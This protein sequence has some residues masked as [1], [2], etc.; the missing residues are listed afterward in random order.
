[1]LNLKL[2]LYHDSPITFSAELEFNFLQGHK[3][4]RRTFS[5]F[6]VSL[7]AQQ[8]REQQH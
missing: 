4:P 6:A 2:H 1:M 8:C 5:S 7:P 3:V